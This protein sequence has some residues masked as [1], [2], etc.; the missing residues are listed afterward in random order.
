[1]NVHIKRIYDDPEPSDGYR[2]LV[3]RLWPRGVSKANAHL[4]AWMKEITPSP[5]LR[6]WFGHQPERFAEFSARYEEEL[7]NNPQAVDQLRTVIA[8]QPA[9]TLLYAAHDPKINHARVLLEY[10]QR[11]GKS[12]A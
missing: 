12:K 1:M 11:T 2:I 5:E 8:E 4:D 3:D 9:V 6:T 10:L 7:H